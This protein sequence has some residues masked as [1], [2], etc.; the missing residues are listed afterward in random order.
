MSKVQPRGEVSLLTAA[1]FIFLVLAV[2]GLS[3]WRF[4]LRDAS[5]AYSGQDIRIAPAQGV[6]SK[7]PEEIVIPAEKTP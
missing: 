6:H 4:V 3:V 5:T 7:Q 1:V 2:S